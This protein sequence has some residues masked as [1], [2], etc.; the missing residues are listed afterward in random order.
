MAKDYVIVDNDTYAI[1]HWYNDADNPGLQADFGGSNGWPESTTHVEVPAGMDP[2]HVSSDS[3]FVITE[4]TTA[5]DAAKWA[6]VRNMR[7][8][9]LAVCDWTQLSDVALAAGKVTE[10]ATYRQELRDLPAT[11][12]DQYNITWPLEPTEGS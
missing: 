2:A 5:K 9:K 12:T 4:D 8:S 7:D 11:E 6:E 1:V 3:S 10:W